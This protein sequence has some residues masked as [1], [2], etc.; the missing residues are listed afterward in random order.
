MPN[1]PSRAS[2]AAAKVKASI[3]S[4]ISIDSIKSAV[5]SMDAF[6]DKTAVPARSSM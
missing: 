2:A 5:L 4:G 1:T 6:S 3:F